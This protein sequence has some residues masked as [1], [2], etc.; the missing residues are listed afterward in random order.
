MRKSPKKGSIL[1]HPYVPRAR[2]RSAFAGL[3]DAYQLLFERNPMPMWVHDAETLRFL[4]VNE[5]AIAHYGHSRREFLSMTV[6]DVRPPEEVPRF[7]EA[8]ARRRIGLYYGGVWKHSKKDGSLIDVEITKHQLNFR[9]RPAILVL[10]NDVTDV[11]RS[12]EAVRDLSARILNAQDEERRRMARELHDTAAQTLSVLAI[13]L[14]ILSE[15]MPVLDA[16]A[17]R[18]LK[19][20]IARVEQCLSEVRSLAYLLHPPVLDKV[21]LHEALKWFIAGYSARSDIKVDLAIPDDFGRLQQEVE[22]TIYRIIQESLVNIQQHSTSAVAAINIFKTSKEV[23]IEISDQGHGLSFP[24][25]QKGSLGVGIPGMRERVRQLGGRLDIL[26][27][28]R[29]TTVRAVIPLG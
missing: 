24:S 6:K 20:S 12:D 17:Q 16:R 3:E 22:V 23:V 10:L 28:E 13:N 7:L 26:S 5:A 21:G 19:D 25:G 1:P 9:G 15:C 14:E 8:V 2:R 18:A 27:S 11:R 29:G 4:A